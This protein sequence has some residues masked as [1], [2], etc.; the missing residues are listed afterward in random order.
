MT[1]NIFVGE[2][3][4]PRQ[5]RPLGT[6]LIGASNNAEHTASTLRLQDIVGRYRADARALNGASRWA[7]ES[8]ASHFAF[9]SRGVA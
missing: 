7:A 3:A 5:A 9:R 8:L 4:A 1:R 6:D 2:E